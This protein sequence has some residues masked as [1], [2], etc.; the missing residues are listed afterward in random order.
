MVS[1][2]VPHDPSADQPSAI[3][4]PVQVDRVDQMVAIARDLA[5]VVLILDAASTADPTFAAVERILSPINE[6]LQEFKLWFH[7]AWRLATG[8]NDDE[9]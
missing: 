1:D 8:A 2:N 7:H 5:G 4:I 9:K 3:L 6:Q